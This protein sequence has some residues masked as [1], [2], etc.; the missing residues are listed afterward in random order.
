MAGHPH[1]IQG[2]T[3]THPAALAGMALAL[4]GGATTLHAMNSEN[5]APPSDTGV[6]VVAI[7]YSVSQ[8]LT[9]GESHATVLAETWKRSLR[10]CDGHRGFMSSYDVESLRPDDEVQTMHRVSARARCLP[11]DGTFAT[12]TGADPIRPAAAFAY[13]TWGTPVSEGKIHAV[14]TRQS[15]YEGARDTIRNTCATTGIKSVRLAHHKNALGGESV[16]GYFTCLP[17]DTTTP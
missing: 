9:D 17:V 1:I 12:D 7:E 5:P 16:E 6:S 8:L 11:D 10:V 4:L 2:R 15:A 14:G 13:E 3:M